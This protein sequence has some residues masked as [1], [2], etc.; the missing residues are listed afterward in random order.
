MPRPCG[1]ARWVASS[2]SVLIA[3]VLGLSTA[4]SVDAGYEAF[5]LSAF[6]LFEAQRPPSRAAAQTDTFHVRPEPKT[7][8]G[9]VHGA[10]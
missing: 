2:E 5:A 6:M 8:G 7:G 10:G 9:H 1:L 3:V 4:F